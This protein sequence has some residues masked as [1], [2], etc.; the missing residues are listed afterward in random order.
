VSGSRGPAA[1]LAQ[2]VLAQAVLAMAVLA[3]A[4]LAQAVLA[5]AA[6]CGGPAEHGAM[7]RR[8]RGGIGPHALS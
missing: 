5:M 8:D 3:Q 1:A 7:V 6:G 2:A 4:V